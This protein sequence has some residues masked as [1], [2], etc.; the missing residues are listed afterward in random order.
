MQLDKNGNGSLSR[1][2]L[3]EAYKN[4]RGVDFDESEIDELMKKADADGNGDINYS[5]WIMT[6]I[7]RSKLLTNEKLE[8]A[9]K[10]FD[11]DGS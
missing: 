7:D 5:E 9:F 2:E 6:S 11:K 4:L 10:L 8:S 1:D 3:L